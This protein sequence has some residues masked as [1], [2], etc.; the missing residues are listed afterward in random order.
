MSRPGEGREW[1]GPHDFRRT[2]PA[3]PPPTRAAPGPCPNVPYALI[4]AITLRRRRG[5]KGQG[6]PWALWG[7]PRW[8]CTACPVRLGRRSPHTVSPPRGVCTL[9]ARQVVATRP[10]R[11][12]FGRQ[13]S[14]PKNSPQSRDPPSCVLTLRGS[15]NHESS[16]VPHPATCSSWS[17][18]Q[19]SGHRHTLRS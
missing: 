12:R 6:D 16:A 19:G 15:A 8:V 10:I 5:K 4:Q 11:C 17:S 13:P 9:P 2:D 14:A 3:T 1:P 18:G 7:F